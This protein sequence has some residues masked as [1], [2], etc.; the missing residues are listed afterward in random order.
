MFE[1]YTFGTS[2]HA[3][4]ANEEP[5]LC[6]KELPPEWNGVPPAQPATNYS[7]DDIDPSDPFS[8]M[9]LLVSK[10]SQQSLR[11]DTSNAL[12]LPPMSGLPSPTLT[13]P[14]S[15]P[16]ADHELRDL[17][18]LPA[19]S[20]PTIPSHEN[21][22]NSERRKSRRRLHSRHPSFLL[23][24]PAVHLILEDMITSGSQ[25]NVHQSLLPPSPTSSI[26]PSQ[27]DTAAFDCDHIEF[28]SSR[29]KADTNLD[30]AGLD[31]FSSMES[32]RNIRRTSNTIARHNQF[33]F[34]FRGS[35]EAALRCQ[36]VVKS[37]PRMR[38]RNHL[39]AT[40]SAVLV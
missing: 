26:H 31:D 19:A 30:Y 18:D 28:T 21:I 6:P 12:L 22:G 15:P 10:M 38:K 5:E 14:P 16:F 35:A 33:P 24:S 3:V 9:D 32:L 23:N 40:K 37:V 20:M 27:M 7:L 11:G 1:Y 25:C 36:H 17:S 34:R 13:V 2:V 29:V 8:N 39:K 4:G